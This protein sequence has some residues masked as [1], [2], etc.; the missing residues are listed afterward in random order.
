MT[1]MSQYQNDLGIDSIGSALAMRCVR[2]PGC[3]SRV[4]LF[5]AQW[6]QYYI[7]SCVCVYSTAH[8]QR[9]VCCVWAVTCAGGEA[10]GGRRKALQEGIWSQVRCRKWKMKM[11]VGKGCGGGALV[12]VGGCHFW[13]EINNIFL[14]ICL[15]IL[16]WK[17]GGEECIFPQYELIWMHIMCPW[18]CHCDMC[19]PVSDNNQWQPDYYLQPSRTQYL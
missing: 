4:Y 11:K 19:C 3:V 14:Q 5:R 10:V 12:I 16:I 8:V 13:R 2:A 6:T 18:K 15:V 1:N 9:A 17:E 7:I